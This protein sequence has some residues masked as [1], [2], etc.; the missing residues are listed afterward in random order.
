MKDTTQ[1]VK[2]NKKLKR[3]RERERSKHT[4]QQLSQ[5]WRKKEKST[6]LEYNAQRAYRFSYIPS[7]LSIEPELFY[8]P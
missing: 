6:Q 2:N 7:K 8:S 3:E 4:F 5:T 1:K